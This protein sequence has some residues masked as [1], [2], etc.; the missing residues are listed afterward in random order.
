MSE[1]TSEPERAVGA[2]AGVLDVERYRNYLLLLA[3]SQLSPR[4]RVRE[5]PSD[6]VQRTLLDA[7]AARDQFRGSTSGEMA[8]WLSQILAHNLCRLARDQTRKK[9]D[10]RREVPLWQ[11]V[12]ES[13]AMLM[14]AI[15]DPGTSPSQQ[16]DRNEQLRRLADALARLP[17]AQREAVELRY[18]H[19]W[20]VKAISEELGRTPAAVGGLLHRG[21]DELQRLLTGPQPPE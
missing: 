16:A 10:V 12:E 11:K 8:A 4:L 18:L 6:V 1:P 21:L 3:R 15:A 2:P 5:A 7:H 20:P 19:R 17:E 14:R 9:R 13:S